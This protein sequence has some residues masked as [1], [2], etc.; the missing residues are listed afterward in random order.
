MTKNIEVVDASGRMYEATY[1]KRARQLVK[2]GRARF[3][4]ES[5]ICLACPP[6]ITEENTMTDATNTTRM[7]KQDYLDYMLKQ[8][9]A[10]QQ[11]NAHIITALEQLAAFEINPG[12]PDSRAMA[13]GNI[14]AE[15]E[16]TNRE[17]LAMY[18][19]IYHDLK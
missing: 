2:N 9:A 19:T 6:E 14:I 10:I 7:N 18:E 15:R 5:R 16:C 12:T 1:P 4:S 3:I 17:L 11:D 8:M 13:M